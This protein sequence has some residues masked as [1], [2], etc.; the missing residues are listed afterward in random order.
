MG[1]DLFVAIITVVFSLAALLLVFSTICL[2]RGGVLY[3]GSPRAVVRA[4][5]T[6]AAIQPGEKVYD[7]GCGDGRLLIPAVQKFRAIATGID[8]SSALLALAWLRCRL[9]RT[10]VRL[11]R[12][13]LLSVD[14]SE[15]D[16]VFLYLMP[17]IIEKLQ[18]RLKRLK[19]GSRVICHQF[20][21]AGWTIDLET[22]VHCWIESTRLIRYLVG[23][24]LCD[25]PILPIP[26]P[27]P[28]DNRSRWPDSKITSFY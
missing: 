13:N 22:D 7:L 1:P 17:E 19:P 15:A 26:S 23:A 14:I 11:I 18:E 16:V 10:P 21:L 25:V 12:K 3:L 8:L 20:G 9:W 28:Q 6:M 5:L 27:P 4:M 24:P 2:I